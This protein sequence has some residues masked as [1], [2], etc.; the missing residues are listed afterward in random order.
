MK[1]LAVLFAGLLAFAGCQNGSS[2]KNTPIST[3]KDSLSYALGVRMGETIKSTKDDI[4]L[5]ALMRGLH[6]GVDEDEIALSDKQLAD[7][8]NRF[9]RTM[10]ERQNNEMKVQ[11]DKNLTE[12]NAYLAANKEK[13]GVVALPS[14]LQ[15]KVITKGTGKSPKATDKVLAHYKGTL[16]DGTQ[17]DSS[18]DRGQP[19]EFPVNRVIKGWTE[20]LQLMKEGSKWEL[21]IPQDL[22]YGSQSRGKIPSGAT[23]LFTVELIEVR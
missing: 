15:Y 23:L 12:G 6:D 16:L 10:Q 5:S 3:A 20:A 1:F 18:Y 2:S 21:Y 8:T 11:M 13:E 4:N 14:G 22:A 17:F 7:H 9:Q 19:S